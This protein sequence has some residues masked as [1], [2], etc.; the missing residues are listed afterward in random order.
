[1]RGDT[2]SQCYSALVAGT[3]NRYTENRLPYWQAILEDDRPCIE[4]ALRDVRYCDIAVVKMIAT[5]DK[6][7]LNG[8]PTREHWDL[9]RAAARD[10]FAKHPDATRL[11]TLVPPKGHNP[12]MASEGRAEEDRERLKE[13]GL[14]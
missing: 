13:Q 14:E 11:R 1:M 5:L 3:E 9:A 4:P 12:V 6:R 10:W 8:A 2:V 7:F